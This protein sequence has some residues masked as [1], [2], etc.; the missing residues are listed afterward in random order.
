MAITDHA[1]GHGCI[2]RSCEARLVASNGGIDDWRRCGLAACFSSCPS[3]A[4]V[5][6]VGTFPGHVCHVL[7]QQSSQKK[8]ARLKKKMEWKRARAMAPG[9]TAMAKSLSES[10]EF[11]LTES[12]SSECC[13]MSCTPTVTFARDERVKAKYRP[14][15]HT[16]KTATVVKVMGTQE[17]GQVGYLLLFDGYTDASTIPASRI[18]SLHKHARKSQILHAEETKKKEIQ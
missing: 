6:K 16:Y 12:S 3:L 2:I 7:W 13:T 15:S 8:I 5:A 17:D 4:A 11:S 14:E 1:P 18:R 10:S 9:A